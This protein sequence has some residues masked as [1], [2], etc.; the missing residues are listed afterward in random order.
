MIN[1][2]G[3]LYGN[4]RTNLAGTDLNRMWRNPRKDLQPEVYYIKKYLQLINKTAPISMIIDLHG[5][6]KSLNSFF[7]GNPCRKENTLHQAEDPRLFPYICSKKIKQISF[8]QST[9][10]VSEDKKNSARV[11]LSELFP[12]ALV[13]TLEN[14]F[15]GWK[16]DRNTIYEYTPEVLKRIGRELTITYLEFERIIEKNPQ[17]KE[18][19][20]K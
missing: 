10:C 18:K 7:Y 3:V 17:I 15:H 13:Y 5:H 19:W 9:F 8:N 6:S 14:S 2:D 16:K 12:K 20:A 1:A 4:Y 11:V